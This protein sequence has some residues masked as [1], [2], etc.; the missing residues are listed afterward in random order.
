[1]GLL[2][3]Y[4]VTLNW[5]VVQKRLG[6]ANVNNNKLLSLSL[7][8]SIHISGFWY[9]QQFRQSATQNKSRWHLT[10]D[11]E[12]EVLGCAGVAGVLDNIHALITLLHILQHQVSQRVDR[13]A[14]THHLTRSKYRHFGWLVAT[15]FEDDLANIPRG[16]INVD[17][18]SK[19]GSLVY[20]FDFYK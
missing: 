19:E 6:T 18:L 20:L 5:V 11:K 14:G 17:V 2:R 12:N 16:D 7:S 8:V 13:S 9:E 4:S 3:A 15:G 10:P 1:M